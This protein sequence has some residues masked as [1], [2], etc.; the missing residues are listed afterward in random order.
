MALL[1][2][3]NLQ[4]EDTSSMA[5]EGLD[6]SATRVN[7]SKTETL[8]VTGCRSQAVNETQIALPGI[9][10]KIRLPWQLVQKTCSRINCSRTG[11]L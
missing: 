6:G 9:P 2:M 4:P 5:H 7:A 8:V 1:G 3:V 11:S 10:S